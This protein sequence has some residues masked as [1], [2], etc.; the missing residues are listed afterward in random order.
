MALLKQRGEAI[1]EPNQTDIATVKNTQ[2]RQ[3]RLGNAEQVFNT[4]DQVD[5]LTSVMGGTA[6]LLVKQETTILREHQCH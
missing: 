1:G 2:A 3:L 6:T 5:N 4:F